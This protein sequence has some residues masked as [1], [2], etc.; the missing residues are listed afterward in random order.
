MAGLSEWSRDLFTW[1]ARLHLRQLGTDGVRQTG[2]V[3]TA[4]VCDRFSCQRVASSALLRIPF[5]SPYPLEQLIRS[6]GCLSVA[7]ATSH[8]TV[9]SADCNYFA[10]LYAG[11]YNMAV[12]FELYTAVKSFIAL[13]KGSSR[14]W[15]TAVTSMSTSS[16]TCVPDACKL[17]KKSRAILLYYRK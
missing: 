4:A 17:R 3:S 16:C 10:E 6:D 11:W 2:S 9:R 5:R 7:M 1:P 12:G 13:L 8:H 14:R 15:Q